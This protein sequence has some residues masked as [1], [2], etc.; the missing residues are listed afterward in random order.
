[1]SKPET[2]F[3]DQTADWQIKEKAG[4]NFFQA[5]NLL[6]HAQVFT[7]A[8]TTRIGGVSPKPYDSF[9]LGRH[10]QDQEIINDAIANRKKLCN[11]LNLN[12]ANLT[13]PSQ[14]HTDNIA[15]I[16]Q[17]SELPLTDAI[18]TQTQALPILLTFAD[19]VPVIA[20]DY[21]LKM[22]AGIHA[23]WRGTA[24]SILIKTIK[25]MFEL[26]S[27]PNNII[28]A[29]GPAIGAC[30]YPTSESTM[31]SLK[32]SLPE[33]FQDNI[34][35]QSDT[36]HPDLKAINY[37]QALSL[38]ITNISVSKYCTACNQN[39]FYSHRKEN[40]LTGRQALIASM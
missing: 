14:K 15:L 11:T 25:K 29:I 6:E 9:N 12:F 21:K 3:L 24:S 23:G 18:I 35:T 26:G 5:E 22:F 8:F 28:L 13:V 2:K 4:L 40:G 34:V 33:K 20:F 7:H 36:P 38:N 30:C 32:L 27:Q 19:C 39:L 37:Y 10:I 31:E 16:S 1:M 17:T